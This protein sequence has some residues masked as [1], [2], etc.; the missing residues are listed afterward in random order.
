MVDL[1]PLQ[2]LLRAMKLALYA[3]PL[4][5]EGLSHK[6][7]AFQMDVLP[8]TISLS[9]LLRT[10]VLL[11][12]AKL[13]QQWERQYALNKRN[14]CM[15]WPG[16]CTCLRPGELHAETSANDPFPVST[17]FFGYAAMYCDSPPT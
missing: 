8:M 5:I 13:L 15:T 2:S 3:T 14:L 11:G 9:I 4:V 17:S 16:L 12:N 10:N 6:I 1:P 7:C